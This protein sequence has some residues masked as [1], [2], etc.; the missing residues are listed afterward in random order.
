MKIE[1]IDIKD[2]TPYA[3]NAKKHTKKQ[4][5]QIEQSIEE[6]G[7]ND[8]IAIDDKG[9][10]I[11]GHGRLMAA[12]NLGYE[13]V[14]CIRISGLSDQQKKAYILVHN[15]LTMNTGFDTE[16]LAEELRSISEFDMTDFD[17]EI[18]DF[19]PDDDD[20]YYG[21]ERERTYNAYNLDEYDGSRAAGKYQLPVLLAQNAEPCKLMSF[22]YVLSSK[23]KDCGVHFYIDD[24]QFERVW[25]SPKQYIDK[26]KEFECVLTPDFSL[27]LDMPMAMKIW[28]VYRSRLIG[29]MMQDAGITVIPTL[30]WA[31][32]ATFDFCFDG[33][34]Q[35]GTVSV[36]TIGVKMDDENKTV[37]YNGMTEAL[38]RIKPQ[39]VLVYGGDIGYKFP[40]GV[41]VKQYDNKAF[42]RG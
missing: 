19:D 22:N 21:D 7:F 36:S 30:T 23:E 13:T 3:K 9:V 8:P 12:Q 2:I 27:Y 38:R 24:Y 41:Q 5:K 20:G 1:N 31:E 6:F 16:L 15:K 18:P 33:I 37:W 34:E 42:K 14:P 40:D 39:R 4:I 25:N 26:L 10:V 11:E 35:G 29:Q 32:P 28:N 17:F